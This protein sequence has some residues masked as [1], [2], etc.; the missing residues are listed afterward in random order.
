MVKLSNRNI[1]ILLKMYFFE[2]AA[3]D[4]VQLVLPNYAA[5]PQLKLGGKSG[6]RQEA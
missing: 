2:F 3:G 5:L 1:R 6:G 4:I